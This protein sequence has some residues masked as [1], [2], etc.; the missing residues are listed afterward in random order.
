[1]PVRPVPP[2]RL[3]PRNDHPLRPAGRWV[4]YWMIAARRTRASHGLQHAAALAEELGR[5]LLVLEPL[6]AGYRHASDRHHHFV[7]EGM[8]A[9]QVALASRP[10]T[11]YPYVEPE[12]GAGSGLLEALAED[13]CAVVTDAYPTF[14][15]P[16]MVQA[17]AAKVTCSM[18]AVDGNGALPLAVAGRDFTTAYSFRRFLQKTLREHLVEG[19]PVD[20]PLADADLPAPPEVPEEVRR[21]WPRVPPDQLE[22]PA[23]LVASLPVDHAVGRGWAEGGAPAGQRRLAAFL[24]AG[25][26]RYAADRNHPDA[27]AES[28]LSPYLHFGH[29]GS[30]QVLLAVAEREGWGT[31]QLGDHADGKRNGWWGMSEGAEE[32]LDQLVTWRELGHVFCARRNRD[33][34]RYAGLPAWARATLDEHRG[35]PR[36]ELYAPEAL[37]AAETGDPVWNAAQRQLV[38]E[39]RL[40]NYMRMLWGKKILQWTE[41]PEQAMEVMVHLNDKYALDGRDP[42]SYSGI[43]WVLGRFDRAWGPERPIFGKVRYMTSQSAQR[44][45]R[46]KAYLERWS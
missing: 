25:L 6:R 16:R 9:N 31:D 4:L 14:F 29:L 46:M 36:D 35:D 34:A 41:T 37:E 15:L 43:G 22:D 19:F 44:K 5:P 39:G 42:N 30:H 24:D 32:F 2:E 18:V 45:L 13:A 11:Y 8:A 38:V 20:D 23:T 33:A 7:I 26:D 10:V 27:D 3:R 1:M 40:H 28:G 21:R 12:P 17:A